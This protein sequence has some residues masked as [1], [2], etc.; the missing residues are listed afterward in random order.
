MFNEEKEIE[1][2]KKE[3]LASSYF[4]AII[5]IVGFSILFLLF[6]LTK[7]REFFLRFLFALGL[8]LA[9]ILIFYLLLKKENKKTKIE[10][11]NFAYVFIDF[12]FLSF[13][14]YYGGG[15]GWVLPFLFLGFLSFSYVILYR[16]RAFLI[17]IF[18]LYM[19]IF[20][21]ASD[22]FGILPTNLPFG[23]GF[24][25]NFRYVFSTTLILCGLIISLSITLNF[26]AGSLQ[27]QRELLKERYREEEEIKQS[28]E[29]RVKA[30]IQELKEISKK[31]DKEVMDKEKEL[32]EKILELEEA[33][34]Q[35]VKK[36]LRMIELKK[37]IKEMEKAFSKKVDILK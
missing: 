14:I 19:V 5:I 7:K 36:E 26:F 18:L 28:L 2:F 1:E 11:L 9:M 3:S 25:N 15:L 30:R 27:R 33:S 17:T 12:I 23:F 35:A 34:R 20:L 37:E 6:F 24:H 31:L 13:L 21:G 32:N 8:Y 22:Y 4:R 29:I 16:G 10:N